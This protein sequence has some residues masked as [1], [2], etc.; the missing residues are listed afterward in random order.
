VTSGSPVLIPGIELSAEENGVDVHMLGYHIRAEDAAFQAEL[1]RFRDDRLNR[2]RKIVERLGTLGMPV[3]WEAVLRLANGGSVGRPHIARAMIEAGHV[4]SLAEAFD[5]FLYTGG[6]AYVSRERLSPEAAVSLI[7]RAGGVAVMAHPG[8]VEDYRAMVERLVPAGLDGVEI[9]H[10]KNSQVVRQNLQAL[11]QKYNLIVTGGS[12]FHRK[13]DPI[14]SETP[15]PT[16]LLDLRERAARYQQQT[17][18]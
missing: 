18:D 1:V 3:K 12:D 8:L 7:H 9:M 16:V 4:S 2:G 10:P 11:A 6:P 14:G 13:E 15:P 17:S 5:R